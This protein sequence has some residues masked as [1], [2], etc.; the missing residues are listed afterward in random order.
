MIQ[1]EYDHIEGI[2]YVDKLKPLKR[3]LLESK[4]KKIVNGHFKPAYPMKFM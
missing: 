4:L 2:L 3:K 1:H